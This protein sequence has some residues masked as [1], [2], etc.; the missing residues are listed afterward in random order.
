[1]KTNTVWRW[2]VGAALLTGLLAVV[3]VGR[4]KSNFSAADISVGNTGPNVSD[5]SDR[6]Q[7]SDPPS[8][9]VMSFTPGQASGRI[10]P[11]L[12][13]LDRAKNPFFSSALAAVRVRER[14]AAEQARIEAEAL[15]QA[16]AKAKREAE[17]EAK[18]KAEEAERARIAKEKKEAE[19]AKKLAEKQSKK[20]E[21]PPPKKD[22]PPPPKV[23]ALHYQGMFAAGGEVGA[24][25]GVDD[26]PATYRRSGD[27]VGT[28]RLDQITRE[29]IDLL[30]TNVPAI[31]L[32]VSAGESKSFTEDGAPHE[33]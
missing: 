26:E 14:E 18:R 12:A 33:E 10:K 20:A 7:D 17:E 9:S 25:I 16:E 19:A 8:K 27:V 31:R 6:D 21:K 32:S 29:S 22:Q 30:S 13:Q 28:F 2:I 1:M 24:L 15:A 23:L 11:D 5:N 3:L 4:A